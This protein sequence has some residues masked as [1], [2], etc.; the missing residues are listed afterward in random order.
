MKTQTHQYIPG[1]VCADMVEALMAYCL[2][3]IS[4]ILTQLTKR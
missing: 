4:D 1:R 2:L 3:Y